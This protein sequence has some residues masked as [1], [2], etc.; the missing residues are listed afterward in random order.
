MFNFL[1]SPF[2]AGRQYL[3]WHRP[4]DVLAFARSLT[5][6]IAVL[7]DYLTGDCTMALMKN[8]TAGPARHG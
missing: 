4:E 2:L 1:S 5:S 3:V 7:D 8:A 6:E